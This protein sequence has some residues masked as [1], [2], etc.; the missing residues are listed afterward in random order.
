MTIELNFLSK[1]DVFS[2]LTQEEL[3]EISGMAHSM[4]IK[5]GEILIHE[6]MH[7]TTMYINVKGAFMI[8]FHH[9]RAM[10]VQDRGEIMGASAIVSP[11]RYTGTATALTDGEVVSITGKDFLRF[12]QGHVQ[13]GDK[14]MKKIDRIF[15][16]RMPYRSEMA[17]LRTQAEHENPEET[18]DEQPQER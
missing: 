13:L 6:G 17:S 1:L 3:L 10:I 8:S 16:Q 18:E 9:D 4:K 5:E 15:T 2:D 12:M 7:A 11:Y 14:M